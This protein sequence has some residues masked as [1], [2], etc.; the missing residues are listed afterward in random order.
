MII[1]DRLSAAD[2]SSRLSAKASHISIQCRDQVTSTNNILKDNIS[3]ETC[4]LIALSQT[5][6][7]GRLG[8]SFF[9][10][11]DT[12]L[13]MSLRICKSFEQ[14]ELMLI[15][16]AAAVAACKALEENG[17]SEVQIKWVNDLILKGRKICG[18]LTETVHSPDFGP[19]VIVGVGI[20]IYPPDEGFP[21]DLSCIAGYAF[22]TRLENLRNKIAAS[23]INHF[24]DFL[25][26]ITASRFINEYRARSCVIGKRINVMNAGFSRSAE[27]LGIDD[28]CRLL[29]R[30]DDGTCDALYSGEISIRTVN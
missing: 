14:N 1:T 7:K 10:P 8:R 29:V 11:F 19:C 13:Y 20:N 21:D 22:P 16:P 9:S 17:C 4:A 5:A 28:E 24:M 6:G 2:I 18:I 23:F 15:T 25:E 12:G 27:A 30:Y 3:N 26:D